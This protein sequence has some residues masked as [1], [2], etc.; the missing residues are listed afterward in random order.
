MCGHENGEPCRIE[1]HQ[2]RE[3]DDEASGTVLTQQRDKK[4]P[5]LRSGR[6]IEF[7]AQLDDRFVVVTADVDAQAG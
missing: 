2:I 3:I 5:K 4:V 6:E 7:A 1:V